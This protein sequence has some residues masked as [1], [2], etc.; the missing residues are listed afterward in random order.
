MYIYVDNPDKTK[1]NNLK[2]INFSSMD[3][4]EINNITNSR[5]TYT[6]YKGRTYQD[7]IYE[8]K[9]SSDWKLIYEGKNISNYFDSTISNII[10][11]IIDGTIDLQTKGIWSIGKVIFS[12]FN[13]DKISSNTSIKHEAK[14][15]STQ[16]EKFTYILEPDGQYYLGCNTVRGDYYLRN[17]LDVPGEEGIETSSPTTYFKSDSWDKADEKAWQWRYNPW[18]E[19]AKSVKYGGKTFVIGY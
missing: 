6:G 12:E 9:T 1:I 2:V 7:D 13:A 10:S 15:Q 5:R 17:Y 8:T 18:L 19:S 4:D 3:L 11:L 14:L 16:V